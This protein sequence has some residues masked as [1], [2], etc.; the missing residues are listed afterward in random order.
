[1][2]ALLIIITVLL[3]LIAAE[4]AGLAFLMLTASKEAKAAAAA[5][6]EPVEMS[7]DDHKE[8]LRADVEQAQSFYD[9]LRNIN[10]FMTGK[11]MGEA[12]DEQDR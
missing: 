8:F 2:T 3:I 6:A 10:E 12:L 4:I 5:A 9:T 1:M 7:E 11:D